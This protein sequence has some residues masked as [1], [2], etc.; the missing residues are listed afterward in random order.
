MTAKEH[1]DHHLANIYAW[2]SG[3]FN[4]KRGEQ[5]E[6]FRSRGIKTSQSALAFD[7]GAGHGLQAVS[8]ANLG[9]EVVAVDFNAK[10]LA[11][12]ASENASRN[13]KTVEQDIIAFLKSPG[14]TAALI[15]CMGDTIAHF[16][17]LKTFNEFVDH[18]FGRLL[19]GG[20]LVLSFRDYS[21]PLQGSDRFIPVRADDTKILTC[22]LE[23]FDD[24]VMVHDILHVREGETWIQKV[25]AYPKLRLSEAIVTE[26]LGLRGFIIAGT[27][28]VRRMIHV[29]AVKPG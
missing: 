17:S 26:A 3:Q 19:P 24:H 29:I 1:Y 7:L 21:T 20:K 8:L 6:Y 16:E 12:L 10:L 25:S 23:Y 11:A 18:A 27:E 28:A 9:F 4:V 2:M 22:F 5:Q 14:D 13:I 15:T